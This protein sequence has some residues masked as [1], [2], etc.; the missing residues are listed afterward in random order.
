MVQ[1]DDERRESRRWF[2]RSPEVE[3]P[4]F[5]SFERLFGARY[6]T[7]IGA[8]VLLFSLTIVGLVI[9]DA[10]L[11]SSKDKSGLERIAVQRWNDRT[12]VFPIEG[13]DSEGRQARFDVVILTKT[14][15]WVKGSTT[16]L[17]RGD[18][19]LSAT[20]IES[21]VLAPQMR[22]GL[23]SARELIAV[24]LASVEGD[25][26][27]EVQRGGLRATRVAEWVRAAVGPSKPIMTLNLGRYLE[28]CS[29]CETDDTSWQRPFM[30]I[31]IKDY[32]AGADIGE[33]LRDAMSGK[34]N[35]PSPD[36]Y[37]TFALARYTK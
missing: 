25:V 24:G 6:E 12:L 4:R 20:D 33:A 7:I 32:D 17:E 11:S 18:V 10:M 22:Q 28:L 5:L 14:Y 36:R 2:A 26:E 30:V 34:A 1:F 21:E 31:A 23:G 16:E 15:G 3:R 37:S 9:K 8:L 29:D 19:L 27:R 13:R 35:L